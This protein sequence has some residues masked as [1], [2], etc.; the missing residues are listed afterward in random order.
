VSPTREYAVE[1]AGV[2]LERQRGLQRLSPDERA[3]VEAL[4]IAVAVGVAEALDSLD[5]YDTATSF[6]EFAVRPSSG[7]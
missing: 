4:A 1:V 2:A 6:P 3:E 7:T 5:R